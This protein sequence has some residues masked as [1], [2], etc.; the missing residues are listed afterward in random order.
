ME[1]PA[2]FSSV[3]YLSALTKLTMVKGFLWK[4]HWSSKYALFKVKGNSKL[5]CQE[6]EIVS[7]QVEGILNNRPLMY[8]SE[9]LDDKLIT[10]NYLIYKE[11]LPLIGAHDYGSD[12]DVE[13]SKRSRI[14]QEKK[15]LV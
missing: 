3:Y 12:E 13:L 10:P 8:Q 9:S 14:L 2:N 4:T 5:K 1:I 15:E 11:P 7:I 6:L